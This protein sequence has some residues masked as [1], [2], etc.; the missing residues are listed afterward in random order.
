MSALAAAAERMMPGE[1]VDDFI[2]WERLHRGAQSVLYRV[3][4]RET[5]FP[6]LMKVPRFQTGDEA[7]FH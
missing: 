2:V 3:T 6:L 7:I 4:G 1:L 5:G